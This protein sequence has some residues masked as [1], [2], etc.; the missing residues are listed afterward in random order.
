MS[1]YA[2]CGLC[3]LPSVCYFSLDAGDNFI[4]EDVLSSEDVFVVRVHV[5]RVRSSSGAPP[6]PAA[7]LVS[8]HL[9]GPGNEAFGIEIL[10]S[11]EA[12][13]SAPR[14]ELI[15]P[16]CSLDAYQVIRSILEEAQLPGTAS[17]YNLHVRR[18]WEIS[19][20]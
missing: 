20:A 6:T 11:R 2:I 9:V 18:R 12:L 16:R 5:C 19:F 1:A 3:Y 10:V 4:S 7:V 14:Y 15:V 13:S 17:S 8:W